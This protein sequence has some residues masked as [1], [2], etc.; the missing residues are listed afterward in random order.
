MGLRDFLPW[1]RRS[2]PRV[3]LAPEGQRWYAIGDIHGR[4]DLL[5]DL[6]RRID[7]DDEMRGE[8]DTRLLFLGDYV[9]RGPDSA[10]ILDLMIKLDTG[11][12]RVV[13]LGGNH[14]EVLLAVA[15]GNR[16]AAALFHKMGGRETLLSYGAAAADYDKADPAG[17]IDLVR[18]HVPEPHLSW[19]RRLR[20]SFRAGDYYFAHAGIRPGIPLDQQQGSDLRWIRGEFLDDNGDHGPIIVHGHS[21]RSEVE[22]RTNRIGIDTG[23]YASGRLTALGLERDERWLLQTETT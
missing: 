7:R 10:A 20:H 6:L 3:A 22:E 13:F 4:Y 23:A 16:K 9:D 18:A 19:L 17:V 21:V 8:T 1:R 2:R 5:D 12:D 14:E 11:D 15:E